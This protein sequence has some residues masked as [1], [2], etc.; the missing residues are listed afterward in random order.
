M[1]QLPQRMLQLPQRILEEHLMML[2]C[3]RN[4]DLGEVYDM[5]MLK[6]LQIRHYEIRYCLKIRQKFHELLVD[7]YVLPNQRTVYDAMRTF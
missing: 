3:L 7:S 1:V 6:F 4:E 2:L 5:Q